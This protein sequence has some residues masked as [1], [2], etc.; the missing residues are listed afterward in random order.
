MKRDSNCK[1]AIS[2]PGSH[3]LFWLCCVIA[4]FYPALALHAQEFRGT[5]TGR[6]ADPSGA[7]VPGALVTAVGPQQ[8]YT[9]KTAS[10][11]NFTIPFVQPGTY[12]VSV[13][14]AGFKKAL[15]QGIMVDVASRV[16]LPVVLEVGTVTQSVSVSAQATVLNTADASGGTVISPTQ[17]QNLPMNGREIYSL[18]SLTPGVKAP[19]VG[20]ASN[21]LNESN[22]Y[23]IN[24]NWGNYNQFSLDGAPVS[25][26]N[27]GGAGT[28][29]FSPSVDAVEEFKVM[30]NTYDAQ[31]GRS[32]G[33]YINTI[34]KNGT[35]QFHGTVYDYWRNSV[36]DAN[37]YALSQAGRPRPFHNQHQF[38][39]T[40]GGPVIGLHKGTF[41]FFSYEG[42][43]EATP[44]SV[45][46]T[47]VTQDEL[48]GADGS[49]NLSGYLAGTGRTAIYDPATTT[50][51][52]PGQDPCQDYTR[53]A[54][55]NNT[56]PADR[57][58]AV[59]VSLLKLLP[60]ANLPGYV[61]NYTV[62]AGGRNQYNQEIARVDHT[63]GAKTH[64]YG[65]LAYWSGTELLNGSGFP[66][67]AGYGG[68]FDNTEET[69]T[70]IVDVT[71]TFTPNLFLDVRASY[72]RMYN[73]NY[74]GAEASGVTNTT[75]D[76]IGLD[77]PQLPTTSARLLPEITTSDGA[78]PN[79]VGSITSPTIFE[80]YDLEPSI[81]QV[82]GPTT[83][84]YGFEV[85]DYQDIA[86]G[87]RDAAG[88]F[89]F[90]P[91]FTQQNPYVNNNDGSSIA[92]FLLGE[93]VSGGV[94]YNDPT[95][96]SYQDY[97][98]YIQDDWKVNPRLALNLGV[99]YENELSPRDRWG[100]LQAGMCFTCTNPISSEMPAVAL[101]NGVTFPSPILGGMEFQANRSPYQN[102]WGI[103]E[104]KFGVSF[105]LR[106]NLVLRGGYGL[107]RALGF[108]L[109]GTS[110]WD[111]TT[112][113]TESLNDNLTPTPYFSKG[114]PFPNG[115]EA[116]PGD[117]EGLASGDGSGMWA[118]SWARKI[119]YTH[120]FSF[121]FE[122][123]AQGGIV[124]D[125]EY[126]GARTLD[127]RAGYQRNHLTPA[128]FEEG[129]QDHAYLDQLIPNPFYGLPLIPSASYLGTQPEV[130]VSYMMV[131]YP[132][133]NTSGGPQMYEWNTPWGY[134][135]YNSLI[136]KATK[137]FSGAGLLAKGLSFTSDFTW[138][139]LISAT[140][141]LNNGLL[142]DNGPAYIIDGTDRPFMFNF[143]GVYHLPFGS[144]GMF[145][146]SA[147]GAA[148][149]LINNWDVDW[150]VNYQSGTPVNYPNTYL[151][152][153]G[154]YDIHSTVKSW[155]TYL[156]NSSPSCFAPFPEYTAVTQPNR[157]EL[158]RNP[159]ATQSQ[160]AVQKQFAIGE[161]RKL[162]FRAEAFNVTNTPIFNGPNT[163][164]PNAPIEPVPGVS[165][166]QPGGFSGYGTVGNSTTN[167]P[168]EIQL[169]LKVLF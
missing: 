153:C 114:N 116:P 61:N 65:M 164:S 145:A 2:H 64:L 143:A 91:G 62:N 20:N 154:T 76:S 97:A 6:V 106:K 92:G 25:Q 10:D 169:S 66:G 58:S 14:A 148:G 131:P 105:Q 60:L 115:Y 149:A 55:P 112:P 11:G 15:E 77:M 142:A 37:T 95:Y 87:V 110:T 82:I 90:G 122:G 86:N 38:G 17:V 147:H 5:I 129:H 140:G 9:A 42:W 13:E 43:R 31:Y 33:G 109:G 161:S 103:L 46:T 21:P 27:G 3:L 79:F 70:P 54:F 126:V 125:V 130:P 48:P 75:P 133:Y 89:S 72:N 107:S 138:S 123:Q 101:P 50:C 45:T 85:S 18:V 4:F 78:L 80:T 159:T 139:K 52:V 26:Q 1:S 47:T 134:S 30:T 167:S 84:H 94:E 104:P 53:Q 39:G 152:N 141:L 69:L 117:S 160:V 71:Y 102:T 132:Q 146:A 137:R 150:I 7:V 8:T 57:I 135:N 19:N 162:Q 22:G 40:L 151:Y 163:S 96:E 144:G 36:L 99:R 51:A 56:I 93:P 168:R 113:Y 108:E 34:V 59:G 127:L 35:S 16:N 29:N 83:L 158:I 121:G 136:A 73:M 49:V 23:S 68:S 118:D 157:T 119:P 155:G 166:E 28:W 24:G 124:W 111:E 98:A 81:T 128:E 32:N 74:D 100:R 156:N 67:A 88:A 41:F 63:F 120:Q 165:P 44:N 12:T